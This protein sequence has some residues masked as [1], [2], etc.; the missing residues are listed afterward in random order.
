M[1]K[2][3]LKSLVVDSSAI[4]V[5]ITEYEG[6]QELHVVYAADNAEGFLHVNLDF[7]QLVDAINW[8]LEH[9]A[10]DVCIYP[11]DGYTYTVMVDTDPMGQFENIDREVVFEVATYSTELNAHLECERCNSATSNYEYFVRKNKNN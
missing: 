9:D 8:L 1:C 4:K 2:E 6:T 11:Y 10:Y 3:S 5:D 7:E